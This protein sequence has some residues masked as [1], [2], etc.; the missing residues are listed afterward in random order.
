MS[1]APIPTVE[2]S[3]GNVVPTLGQ[4][5]W[6]MGEDS[7]HRKEE[8]AALQLGLDLGM[9]LIDTAEMYANGR[10]EEVVGEAIAGRRQHVFLVS[11]VLPSNASRRGTLKACEGSLRRMKTECLD[12]YLLHWRGSFPLG[13][14]VEAFDELTRA[15]KI[16]FWGVSNFDTPDMQEV[17][18][19]AGGKA[20][21][22]NQVLYNL[23]RRGIEYDLLDWCRQRQ[24]SI[25]AYSPIEQG[26]MLEN[27]VLKSVASRHGAT[28]AQ[29]ALT[30]LLRQPEVIVIPKAASLEHVR[31]NRGALDIRLTIED[32]ADL[33]GAFPPP[34][35]KVPLEML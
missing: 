20:M 33:D 3:S 11:K 7:R 29:V 32:L 13:E 28:A 12:L 30:W 4:G 35:S 21:A 9:S 15:G 16:K 17:H 22:T 24:I 5:T 34:K 25:M 1:P 19:L 18:G 23:K 10:A 26:R 27:K 14:T 31:E 2:L 6:A 8:V